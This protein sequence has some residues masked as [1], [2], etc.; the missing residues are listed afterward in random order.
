M[1]SI[2]TY[3]QRCE[4][5]HVFI[6][7]CWLTKAGR[8]CACYVQDPKRRP[9]R[10][11]AIP[12]SKIVSNVSVPHSHRS[13]RITNTTNIDRSYRNLKTHLLY[14]PCLARLDRLD[15]ALLQIH[16]AYLLYSI[17]QIQIQIHNSAALLF[18]TPY[19]TLPYLV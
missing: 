9:D 7:R 15:P 17:I 16:P 10:Q 14:L 1:D 6:D 8:M 2:I 5:I 3:S 11:P 12:C 4:T 18:S 19:L 13:T